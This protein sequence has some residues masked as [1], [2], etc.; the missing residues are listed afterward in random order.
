MVYRKL[1]NDPQRHQV[2]IPET[3]RCQLILKKKKKVFADV[4]KLGILR[5]I[6][7]DYTSG[8]YMKLQVSLQEK[9]AS[10]VA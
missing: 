1:N 10:L 3:G 6:I 9:R 7:L 5:Q 2:L 4:T 8:H